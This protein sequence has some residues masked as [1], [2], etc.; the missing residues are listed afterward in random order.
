[1]L[2]QSLTKILRLGFETFTVNSL[3]KMKK[4]DW[5]LRHWIDDLMVDLVA[6]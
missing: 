3:L 1:M 2:A 4:Y 5:L 6:S